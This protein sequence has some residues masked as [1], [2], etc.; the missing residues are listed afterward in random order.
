[1]AQEYPAID[2]SH[3]PELRRLAEEVR[4]T[5]KAQTVKLADGVVA[6]VKPETLTRHRAKRQAAP[7][8]L[9]LRTVEDVFGAVP[10][11]RHLKGKDIDE[12]IR[13]AKE[14]RT[15]RPSRLH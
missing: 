14:E 12:M 4:K 1:M 10:T 15:G 3:D 8:S 7:P 11:P 13:E 2:I 9:S 5:R 6:V